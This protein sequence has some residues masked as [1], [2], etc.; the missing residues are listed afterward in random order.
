MLIKRKKKNATYDW[1][2]GVATWSGDVKPDRAGPVKLQS[3]DLDALL[4][5]LAIARDAVASE[6]PAAFATS[7][8]LTGRW[9]TRRSYDGASRP[10]ARPLTPDFSLS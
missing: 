10:R 3:G 2:R 9:F 1:G 7:E 8:R 6:T 5:N 4:V